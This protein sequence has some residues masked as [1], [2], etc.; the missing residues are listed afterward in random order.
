MAWLFCITGTVF[1]LTGVYR[2]KKNVFEE[3]RRISLA[4]F[5]MIAGVILIAVGTA[6]YFKLIG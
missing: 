3:E 1:C 4:V 2:F 5:L 6:R